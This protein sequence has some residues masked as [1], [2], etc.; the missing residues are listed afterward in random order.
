M[1][2]TTQ[3]SRGLVGVSLM[4]TA[5][6]VIFTMAHHP[7]GSHG[8]GAIGV[9]VHGTMI[10]LMLV[11][12]TAF[13]GFCNLHGLHRPSVLGGIVCY[14]AATIANIGAAT[15][16]GFVLVALAAQGESVSREIFILCW[17]INQA[18]ARLGV[19][20]TGL[21]FLLWSWLF[22]A[23]SDVLNKALGALAIVVGVS[24]LVWLLGVSEELNVTVALAIYGSH[25]LWTFAVGYQLKRGVV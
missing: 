10:V 12:F 13:M 1:N 4:L 17:E 5:L 20:T 16:N 25:A 23:K 14:G 24:P 2:Q 19:A 18:L 11:L 21:A 8:M 9:A 15:M 6:L 7:S 22:L 3:D